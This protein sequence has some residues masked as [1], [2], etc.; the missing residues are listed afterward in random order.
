MKNLYLTISETVSENAP[1][2]ILYTLFLAIGASWLIIYDKGQCVLMINSY[3][4]FVYDK[5]FIFFTEAGDG[6]YFAIVLLIAGVIGLRYMFFGLAA[7]LTAGIIVRI[8]KALIDSPRPKGFFD[9]VTEL[10]F[11]PGIDVHSWNSMPSGH[12]TTG[13]VIFLFFAVLIKDKRWSAIMFVFALMVG[14]SRVYLVQHF[15]VDVY[16]GSII[17]VLTTLLM[18][19]IFFKNPTLQDSKFLNY[20]IF[21]K[22]FLKE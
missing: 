13:F 9:G 15:F 3:H 8:F 20:S 5:I 7:Y 16:F 10:S 14:I 22:Y 4:N 17:G 2:F 18:Y 21:N 1:F 6:K 12:T 19:S 11:V